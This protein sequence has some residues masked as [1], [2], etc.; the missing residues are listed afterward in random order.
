MHKLVLKT[1]GIL[2]SLMQLM[3]I[4]IVFTLLM[5]LLYWIKNLAGFSYEFLNFIKPVLDALLVMGAS[6]ATGS[7]DLFS[8]TFEYK[9]GAACIILIVSFVLTHGL[10]KVINLVEEGYCQGRNFIKKIEENQMN[11]S[12]ERDMKT[13]QRKIKNFQ[14]YV[15]LKEKKKFAQQVVNIDM[16]EQANILNKFLIEKLCVNPTVYG[17]GYLYSFGNIERLDGVLEVLFKALNSKAPVDYV[18]C[19]QVMGANIEFEKQQLNELIALDIV[20]KIITMPDTVWCYKFN[21]RTKYETGQ[22]GDFKAEGK[23]FEVHEFKDNFGI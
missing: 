12:L 13:E 16:K 4:L 6:F 2:R 9:Y 1:F 14:V 20:N 15:G 7:V 17:N 21:E 10:D 8:A 19:I 18:V 11:A 23:V 3:R 22:L 5:L